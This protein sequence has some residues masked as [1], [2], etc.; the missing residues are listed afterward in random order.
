MILGR[1]CEV[2]SSHEL[3]DHF[4][5]TA[6]RIE[7]RM[8]IRDRVNDDRVAA[9]ALDLE[10]DT[11]E[12]AA[13]GLHLLVLGLRE[14]NREG[15]EKPLATRFHVGPWN[16]RNLIRALSHSI[17]SLFREGQSPYP[18]E[19]TLMTT[20]LLEAAMES[21]DQGGVSLNTPQ[22]EFDYQTRNFDAMR[23]MGGTWKIITDDMEQPKGVE[24]VLGK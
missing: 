1:S 11:V 2:R 21:R 18:V 22:L 23:E 13:E 19:R 15:K 14:A 9:E 4:A 20:G 3:I 5:Q 8:R 24:A 6:L 17:Q 16:N 10:A 7:V 12:D